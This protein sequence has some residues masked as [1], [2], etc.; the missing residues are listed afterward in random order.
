[1]YSPLGAPVTE[2]ETAWPH[3]ATLLKQ[4]IEA[5]DADIVCIQVRR[6]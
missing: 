6:P 5:A 4:Q 2:T 1:M 3:R